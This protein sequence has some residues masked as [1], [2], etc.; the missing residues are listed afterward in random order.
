MKHPLKDLLVKFGSQVVVFGRW[1]DWNNWEQGTNRRQHGF[2]MN[3]DPTLA[4]PLLSCLA[5]K[6]QLCRTMAPN[7]HGI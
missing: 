6:H 2:E 3:L 1:W 4:L 7:G 5:T